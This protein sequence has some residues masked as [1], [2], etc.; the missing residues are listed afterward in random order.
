MTEGPSRPRPERRTSKTATRQSRIGRALTRGGRA[1][2]GAVVGAVGVI[3]VILSG[4]GGCGGGLKYTVDDAV[5]DPIPSEE[6]LAVADA[7]KDLALAE[8][9]K[10]AALADLDA[11]GRDRTAADSEVQQAQL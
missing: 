9:E 11:L 8:A 3:G 2:L 5:M 7:R 10:R 4:A 1:A 6:R